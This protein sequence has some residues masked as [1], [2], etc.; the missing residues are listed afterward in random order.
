M[1]TIPQRY[2]PNESFDNIPEYLIPDEMPFKT[3]KGSGPNKSLPIKPISADSDADFP[4]EIPPVAIAP[5]YIVPLKGV[6]KLLN[7]WEGRITEVRDSEFDAII[8]DKT[9]PDF[10]DELVTIDKSEITPDDFSMIKQGA[11]FYWSVGYSDYPGRGRARES[12]IRF[13]RLM[14]WT[15]AEINHA[16]KIGKEFA[17]FFKSNSI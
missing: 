16:K 6:F 7:L 12:K 14:G 3:P 4:A 15:E 10:A 1:N 5:P 17:E 2:N 9:N 8:T 13:R 11:V